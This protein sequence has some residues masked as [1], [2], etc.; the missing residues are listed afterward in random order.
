M[1]QTTTAKGLEAKPLLSPPDLCGAPRATA[2]RSSS[3]LAL[4]PRSKVGGF[5]A[6][7]IVSNGGRRAPLRVSGSVAAAP[8]KPSTV[9]EIVL[10]P[11]REIS[12][13]VKLPGSKSL[14]NRIL[15]LAALS[16][17]T[18][19]VDNL[20]YSDDVKYMLAA[21]RTLGLSVEDDSATKRATVGGCG[22][23]FPLGKSQIRKLSSSWE[24]RHCYASSDCCC[25]RCWWQCKL[26]AGWGAKDEGEAYWRLGC[27]IKAAW[28]GC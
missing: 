2:R 12:G 18:T 4:R 26:R 21:L 9:P 22:G 23:K 11:I 7:R 19:V 28:C 14:S 15:L 16:E 3:S 5:G 6:L 17:G 25:Y 8:E 20:L 1:A 24:C 10:Q 13:T 27:R